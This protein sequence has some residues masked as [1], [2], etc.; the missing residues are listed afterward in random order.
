MDNFPQHVSS[1]L[2]TIFRWTKYPFYTGFSTEINDDKSLTYLVDNYFP[3]VKNTFSG[4]NNKKLDGTKISTK[5]K[6]L[7]HL[8]EFGFISQTKR[9]DYQL[10]EYG[11]VWKILKNLSNELAGKTNF[12]LDVS[13]SIVLSMALI[14]FHG[15]CV[16][17]IL[18][19]MYQK[20][21]IWDKDQRERCIKNE[22]Q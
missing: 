15:D 7:D 4:R 11:Y 10:D 22:K 21:E 17:P 8:E 1:Y 20:E 9:R 6:S 19:I 5:D 12:N 2:K 13:N 3:G 16:L 18:Q 14:K